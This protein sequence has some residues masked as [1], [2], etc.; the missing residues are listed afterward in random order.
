MPTTAPA[1]SLTGEIVLSLVVPMFNEEAAL[2]VFIARVVPIVEALVAPLGGRYEVICVDDGSTDGT[3]GR[4]C[5]LR[6]GNPAIKIVS[7]SR[8]FGKDTALSAGLDYAGGGAVVPIDADLQDP[9]EVIAELFAKWLE[10]YD[11]VYATR[12]TRASDSP[13]KRFT[14]GWFYRIHNALAETKIPSDTGDFRLMDRR[15]VEALRR[16]PERSRFM[17]GLFA[18]IGFRQTG[19]SYRRQARAAGETKWNYWR[20][21]NFALDGIASF[22][23]LPLRVW[24]YVG[25]GFAL[26]AF[27]YAIFLFL[28]TIF[29]AADVPGY[30]SLMVTVLFMGGL[31]LLTLGIIGEYLARTYTEVKGRPLY[32]VQECHGFDGNDVW[33]VEWNAKSTPAWRHMKTGTGGS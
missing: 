16:L 8:N 21:W 17:K 14:A 33:D 22:S 3:L 27:A 25:V 24:T 18:W 26:F 9:P 20:L 1:Q 2:E 29:W 32:L 6:R 4:L 5:A 15:V 7:L 31:N 23:S 28:R 10:G 13:T 19:V 30:A 12:A 11:V